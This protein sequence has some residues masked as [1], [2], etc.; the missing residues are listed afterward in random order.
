MI[1][2]YRENTGVQ[3]TIKAGVPDNWN[4]RSTTSEVADGRGGRL[5]PNEREEMESVRC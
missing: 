3:T 2:P 4:S 5:T 1:R